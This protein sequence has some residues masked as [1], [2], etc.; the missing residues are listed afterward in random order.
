MR[1]A[2][3]GSAHPARSARHSGSCRA[4]GDTIGTFYAAIKA[5]LSRRKLDLIF[6]GSYS[7]AR[8][9]QSQRDG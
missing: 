1:L 7:Y 3:G 6:A 8:A 2:A 5:N 4:G 9:V